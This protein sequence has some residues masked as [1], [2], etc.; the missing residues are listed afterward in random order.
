MRARFPDNSIPRMLDAIAHVVDPGLAHRIHAF[1]AEHPVPQ[2]KLVDQ[3]LEK[4][5]NNGA[6]ATRVVPE[7]PTTLGALGAMA[8]L[9]EPPAA[10]EA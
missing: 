7:L 2:E 9:A 6:F 8:S 4:L 1:L 5:D 3:S 10:A